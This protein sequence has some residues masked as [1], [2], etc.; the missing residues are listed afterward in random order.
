VI[1]R[2]GIRKRKMEKDT[3]QSKRLRHQLNYALREKK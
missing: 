3:V 1:A 2:K